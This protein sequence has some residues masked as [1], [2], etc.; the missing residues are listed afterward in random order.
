MRIK[1]KLILGLSFLFSTIIT[2]VV[3]S[4]YYVN[5]ISSVTNIILKDN[6]ITLQYCNEMLRDLDRFT[7]DSSA[8]RHFGE[9][10]KMQENNITESGEAE[11]TARLRSHFEKIVNN[12]N[13]TAY[14]DDARNDIFTIN[15][16]NQKAIYQKN[17][18]ALETAKTAN[19]W[20]KITGTFLALVAFSFLLNFPGI[21]ANPIRTLTEGIKEIADKNYSRR[22]HFNSG[23]EFG[24]LADAFNRMAEKLEGYEH[25]NL[26]KVIMEK[27]RIDTIINNLSD[28]IIGLDEKRH[29]LF[30]NEAA[31]RVLG[32]NES[33]LIG[34]YAPDVALNNDLLRN[35]LTMEGAG[36]PLK[37]YANNKES[38]FFKEAVKIFSEEKPVGE[39]IMLKNVTQFKELDLAKTN[40]IATISHELKTPIASIKMSLQLLEDKRVGALNDEQQKL[41]ANIRDDSQRLLKITTELL[42]L[43][44]LESGNMRMEKE[45]VEAKSIVDY[46][47]ESLKAQAD[48]KQL[49]IVV[50][51]EPDLPRINCDPE[52]TA[53]VLVNLLSNAI[54]YSPEKS[55]V[56]IAVERHEDN[57]TFSVTDS[58]TGIDPQYKDKVFEKFFRVPNRDAVKSGTGMG[59]AI[60][61]EFVA[62]QGGK[63]WVESETGKGSTFTFS[64]PA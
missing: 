60:S 43:A 24:E 53:W 12:V 2:L 21:I 6:Y 64:L 59:L 48:Q 62:A 58:G 51:L 1:T 23:D 5:R 13:D 26:A 50:R 57:V 35:L 7:F 63:I 30:A 9:V 49:T 54:R 29:I 34:Y 32:I 46:A 33:N 19:G 55:T 37:I 14:Y 3:L 40:F 27:K 22:I 61:K 56:Q 17:L 44:Q 41:V 8:V 28:P 11:A 20:L 4:V 47:R 45:P 42:D 15:D 18:K 39:V 25:S 31:S 38:F 10:L 36:N 16:L 52:K